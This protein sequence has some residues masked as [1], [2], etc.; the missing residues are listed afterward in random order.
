MQNNYYRKTYSCV[1]LNYNKKNDLKNCLDSILQISYLPK[2]IIVVD[3]NSYDG[4]SS[5]VKDIFKQ[6]ILLKNQNNL[7]CG[8]GFNTGI[9]RALE[10]KSDFIW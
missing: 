6:V 5:M 8:G 3:N 9:N 4:S 1:I 2:M 10:T 7:G